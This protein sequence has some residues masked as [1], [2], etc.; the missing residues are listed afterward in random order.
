MVDVITCFKQAL[1]FNCNSH[2]QDRDG[3]S[4]L[5]TFTTDAMFARLSFQ[6]IIRIR[7]LYSTLS[8]VFSKFA[9]YHWIFPFH[10]KSAAFKIAVLKCNGKHPQFYLNFTC[11]MDLNAKNFTLADLGAPLKNHAP[12]WAKFFLTSRGYLEMLAKYRVG[13]HMQNFLSVPDCSENL[14]SYIQITM[15]LIN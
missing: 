5:K 1:G 6:S 14:L 8:D 9:K 10:Y 12:F 13:T 3:N 11:E 2:S 4:I 7:R 15:K